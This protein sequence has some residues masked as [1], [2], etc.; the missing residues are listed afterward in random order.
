MM[1]KVEKIKQRFKDKIEN[2]YIHNERRIYIN[3]KEKNTI[4]EVAEYVFYDLKMRFNIASGVDARNH[5]E[6]LYHFSDDS[7]GQI[8]S[9]RTKIEKENPEIVSIAPLFKAAQWI[10]REIW[11]LL[12]INFV[13]HPNLKRLLLAE[14]W[15]EGKYPLR[16]D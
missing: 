16:H 6:I 5:L 4:K 11:E 13:G 7:R 10:E 12:G 1:E 15:P 3:L 14:D 2:V 9:F 8:I